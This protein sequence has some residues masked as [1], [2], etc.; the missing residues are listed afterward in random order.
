MCYSVCR[1]GSQGPSCFSQQRYDQEFLYHGLG[2]QR[3]ANT[4]ARTKL[5]FM[6]VATLHLMLIL[7][8]WGLQVSVVTVPDD[9]QSSMCKQQNKM[10]TAAK[11]SCDRSLCF[12]QVDPLTL[13]SLARASCSKIP[14]MQSVI[15]H[16][17]TGR[18]HHSGL[19]AAS[20]WPIQGVAR[21]TL[22]SF[23]RASCTRIFST[24]LQAAG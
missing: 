4:P 10:H 19:L 22:P 8:S 21:P 17:L 7:S 3:T 1:G 12:M 16:R 23:A 11:A 9:Q 13:P 15:G 5:L 2:A 6:L 24:A 18:L 14:A 20:S